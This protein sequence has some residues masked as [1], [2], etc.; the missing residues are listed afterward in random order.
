M[1]AFDYG[2]YQKGMD[3]RNDARL[4]AAIIAIKKELIY[5]GFDQNV[6]PELAYFGDAVANR[7]KEFQASKGLQVDGQAGQVTLT[8]LFRKRVVLT[9]KKFELTTGALGKKLKL[10]SGYDPIAIGYVDPLDTG[11]AQINLGAHPDVTKDEAFDPEF[12]IN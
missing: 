1:G 11:I 8:E 12:A 9:E 7:L 2:R 6:N 5:N 10:E 4:G 3:G